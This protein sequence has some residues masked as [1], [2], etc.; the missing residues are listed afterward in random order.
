MYGSGGN[1]AFTM[2]QMDRTTKKAPAARRN[3]ASRSPRDESLATI[4][5]AK[6]SAPSWV[7]TSASSV[8][9]TNAMPF[10]AAGVMA[11]GEGRPEQGMRHPR[12]GWKAED[13]RAK[14]GSRQTG[15]AEND[16]ARGSVAC[17]CRYQ[18]EQRRDEKQ[19]P[20]DHY[21]AVGIA[22]QLDVGLSRQMAEQIDE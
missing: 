22:G 10:A 5:T 12:F 14:T 13:Q 17:K 7:K 15:V 18:P 4:A 3:A 19:N 20:V 16:A 21:A 11:D 6:I 2:A 9:N 1:L 8:A